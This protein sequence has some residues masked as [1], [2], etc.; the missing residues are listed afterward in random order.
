MLELSDIINSWIDSLPDDKWAEWKKTFFSP[1]SK[2]FRSLFHEAVLDAGV[3]T[4]EQFLEYMN[5]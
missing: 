4:Y 2:E 1:E 3:T 5:T